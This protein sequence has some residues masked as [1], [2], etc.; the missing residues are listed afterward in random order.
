MPK[1]VLGRGLGALLAVSEVD[2]PDRD[3]LNIP[4]QSIQP[5][6]LQPRKLF[7]EEKLRE[8]A[9]SIREKGLIQPIVVSR[10]GDQYSLI[11]GERR[12]RAC[13]LVG[14]HTIPAI[15]KEAADYEKLEL[16]LIENIQREDLNSIEE[17]TS[18][19]ELL[20]NLNLTHEQLSAKI[21]KSRTAISNTLRLLKL[22]PEIQKDI[23]HER[24]S[25]GH[26]R[27]L[28]SLSE[29]QAIHNARDLIIKDKLSV[30]QAEKLVQQI[31]K[32]GLEGLKA[33]HPETGIESDH[34]ESRNEVIDFGVPEEVT[35]LSPFEETSVYTIE[36]SL[37]QYFDAEVR[38]KKD[39]G[40]EKG[41][42]EIQ[43]Q[44]DDDLNRILR[45]LGIE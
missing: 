23:T 37:T 19:K 9:D 28:L 33:T 27:S 44:S 14:L 17:A 18:Y 30:R 11:V 7:D 1:K 20:E 3:I 26:G 45:V 13:Q 8:L 15:I 41:T 42:I 6:P 21:G 4:V 40:H 36:Q 43:Y 35:G 39:T 38:V 24:L 32:E 25:E 22:P 10:E 29:D 31:N 34:S 16:A 2:D 5:N 12:W